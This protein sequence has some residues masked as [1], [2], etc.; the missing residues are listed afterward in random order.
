MKIII[1]KRKFRKQKWHF[2]IVAANNKV[3][4]TSGSEF[5]CNKQD[6]LDTI[7][8][9]KKDLKDAEIIEKLS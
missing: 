9:L 1:G 7:E 6:M 5:Y 4:A 3:V 2:K 8:L